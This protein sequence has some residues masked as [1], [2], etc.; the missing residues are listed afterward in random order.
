MGVIENQL[1]Y[2]PHFVS[3]FHQATIR[4]SHVLTIFRPE[5]LLD[6]SGLFFALAERSGAD[7]GWGPPGIS[8]RITIY[9]VRS[10]ARSF[11][12]RED[13]KDTCCLNDC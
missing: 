10:T 6:L 9:R 4:S 1:G 5:D 12:K 3:C 2:P 13:L 11:K 7:Y 8:E